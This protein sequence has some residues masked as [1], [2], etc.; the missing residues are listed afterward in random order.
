M[1]KMTRPESLREAV[2]RVNSLPAIPTVAQEILS[3]KLITDEGEC[4]LLNLI[5]QDPMLSAKVIGLSNAAQ[6]GASRKIMTVRDAVMLLGFKRVKM[7]ALSFAMITSSVRERAGALDV[8]RLWQHSLSIAMAMHTMARAMPR[9]TR[10]Q[11]DEIFLAGLLHDIGFLV[12]DHI[13]PALSDEF[14]ARMNAEPERSI[15]EIEAE[16]LELSHSELG[17][18]LGYYWELPEAIVAVLRYHHQPADVRATIGRPLVNMANIAEKLL[19]TFVVSEN[20]HAEI[21]T[22]EWQVLG[23]D[24]DRAEEIEALVQKNNQELLATFS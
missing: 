20:F 4:A 13:D 11:D 17:G 14:H 18:E 8:Q 7:V 9:D 3:L 22:E 19:P 1:D 6:F 5:K 12:L 24:P 2:S 10:P 21:K 16:M 23:I 15:A